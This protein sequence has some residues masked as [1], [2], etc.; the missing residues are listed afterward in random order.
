L[1]AYA[2]DGIVDTAAGETDADEGKATQSAAGA[3]IAVGVAAAVAQQPAPS[4]QSAGVKIAQQRIS[5]CSGVFKS[6]RGSSVFN[7]IV[8]N[9]G[10]VTADAPIFDPLTGKQNRLINNPRIYAVFGGGKIFLNPVGPMSDG[11]WKGQD[12]MSG[13]SEAEAYALIFMHET[14]HGTGDFPPDTES[15]S[16]QNSWIIRITCFSDKPL[17]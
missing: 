2:G 6:G 11:R 8:A 1:T 4:P 9:N 7:G 13:L 10:I 16:L 15:Q 14:A 3:G 17:R 5:R 12:F